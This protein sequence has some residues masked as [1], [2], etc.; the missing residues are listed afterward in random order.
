MAR[1]DAAI[2]LF[3]TTIFVLYGSY[4][5]HRSHVYSLTSI[6][7]REDR[8]DCAGDT[9]QDL[10]G[11]GVRLGYYFQ[12]FSGWVSNNFIVEEIAGGLDANSIFLGSLIISILSTTKNNTLTQVDAFILLQLCAGTIWSVLSVWGYRTCVYRKE[13]ADG[14]RRFGGFGTHFR[15]MLGAAVAGYSIWFWT[16]GVRG[17]P[18]GG[19][20]PYSDTAPSAC[21]KVSVFNVDIAG[22][23]RHAVLA[24]GIISVIYTLLKIV[25]APLAAI[26][27]I[28]KIISFV[29]AGQWASSSRLRYAPGLS[30]EG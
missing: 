12:W 11:L 10:Y 21:V 9:S 30:V 18:R 3:C 8:L 15:L 29:R 26:T 5:L 22:P 16:V 7:R 23:V 27:R 20:D 13:G 25:V 6:V 2:L 1:Q 28:R 14:I 24:V 4:L 17:I 19:I